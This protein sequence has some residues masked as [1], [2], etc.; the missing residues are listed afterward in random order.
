MIEYSK[1]DGICIVRLNNPPLNAI[2]FE[3][4]EQL[5]S[6]FSRANTDKDVRG[7]IV[8]GDDDHFSAGADVNIFKRI[9]TSLVEQGCLG[10]KTGA[11][12]YKY[13]KGDYTP[14]RSETAEEVI[15]D[16][17]KEASS[18]YSEIGREEITR[19]LVLRMVN[20]AFYV[21]EDGI[22]ERESDLDVAMVLGT[23]FPDFRGGILKYARDLGLDHVMAQLDELAASLGERFLPARRRR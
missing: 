5:C 8:T 15:L 19:R 11:G 6:A 10:Q 9:A 21:M 17:R 1:S 18:A 2:G 7:I 16:V 22:A 4:L 14:H 13:E 12:V 20:E 3:L 23:G